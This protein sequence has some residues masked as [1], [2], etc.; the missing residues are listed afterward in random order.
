[1]RPFTVSTLFVI[2]ALVCF[3]VA[4]VSYM[5]GQPPKPEAFMAAGLV[6]Y[7]VSHLVP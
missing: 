6:F 5:F 2:I 1:M 7:M 3:L 4:T